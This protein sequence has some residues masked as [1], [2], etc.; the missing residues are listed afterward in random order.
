MINKYTFF[1]VETTGI[2]RHFSQIISIYAKTINIDT[3][4]IID[5][6]KEECCL[7][8][9]LL[10]SPEALIINKFPPAK[11]RSGQ[12]NYEMLHKV[13]EYFNRHSPQVFVAHNAD[14]DFGMIH[15]GYYQNLI[16]TDIY[17]LKTNGNKL[18]CNLQLARAIE[19]FSESNSIG[20]VT[21]QGNPIFKLET[22]CRENGIDIVAHDA[23][24]DTIAMVDLFHLQKEFDENIFRQTLKCS[25][26]KNS[27]AFIN[28]N[29]VFFAALGTNENFRVR[30]LTSL[31][32][33]G[34]EVIV[35][36][37]LNAFEDAEIFSEAYFTS[38]CGRRHSKDQPILK[39]PLNKGICFFDSSFQDRCTETKHL[40]PKILFRKASELKRS[41]FLT[42][43][44]TKNLGRYKEY[45]NNEAEQLIYSEGFPNNAEKALIYTFNKA[46]AKEKLAVLS[47]FRKK[48]G[49]KNRFV[50][51]ASRVMIENYPDLYSQHERESYFNWYNNRL[52][53]Y[54]PDKKDP[55]WV[56]FQDGLTEID[57]LESKY[58]SDL[59][60]INQVK[61]FFFGEAVMNGHSMSDL[62][63]RDTPGIE[64]VEKLNNEIRRRR[65]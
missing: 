51:L 47:N 39:L 50:R 20:A 9:Y 14:F 60:R 58:P 12:S 46:T 30:P 48:L 49:S 41:A 5:E 59:K 2:S 40:D 19:G 45:E 37:L 17:Q 6:L 21:N 34:N 52:F 29:P 57:L 62:L 65:R 11:L 33:N 10:P 31:A 15:N 24:G 27:A 26:T 3:G 55:P 38:L 61:N 54:P 23:E 18:L 1:D 32:I 13:Y 64:F 8:S 42:D 36:D 43:L 22:L 25:E 56:T 44:A 28:Q 53:K 63:L 16:T 35:A 4:E 7:R